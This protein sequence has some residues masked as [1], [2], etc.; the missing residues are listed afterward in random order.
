[1][2]AAAQHLQRFNGGHDARMP[3]A[4][5]RCLNNQFG[6]S[7][8]LAVLRSAEMVIALA[9]VSAFAAD[10]LPVSVVSRSWQLTTPSTLLRPE[11]YTK[12]EACKWR[13][14]YI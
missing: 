7:G 2:P 3:T 9:V 5:D 4:A 1:M 13:M 14:C 6:L 11:S 8:L 12:S 10:E